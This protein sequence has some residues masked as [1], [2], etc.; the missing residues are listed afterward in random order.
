MP[1][2]SEPDFL[3]RPLID[4]L[5]RMALAQFGGQDGVRDEAALESAVG[6]AINIFY[7]TPNCD[8]CDVAAAYAHGLA[9]SQ[10]YIDGNKRVGVT[11]ALTFLELNGIITDRITEEELYDCMIAIAERRLTREQLASK[12]RSRLRPAL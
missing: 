6:R 5:H 10:G 7:Y 11:A 12:L 9:E 4:I 8:L 1:G 3:D 2:R